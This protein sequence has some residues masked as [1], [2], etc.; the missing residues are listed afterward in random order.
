MGVFG[1][2]GDHSNMW[3]VYSVKASCPEVLSNLH[4]RLQFQG[5]QNEVGGFK[6][7]YNDA[8]GFIK[9]RVSALGP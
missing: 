8:M 1:E 7:D 4:V 3:T 9:V 6:A 5:L 2:L